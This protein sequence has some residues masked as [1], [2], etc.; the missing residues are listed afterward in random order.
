M[1]TSFFVN[2]IRSYATSPILVCG[3]TACAVLACN[4]QIDLGNTADGGA[5]SNACPPDPTPGASEAGAWD[6][7]DLG[8]VVGTWT[9]YT[10]AH[11]FPSG[12]DAIVMVFASAS[13]GSVTGTVTYGQGTPPPPPTDPNV[14]YLVGTGNPPERAPRLIEGFAYTAVQPSFDGNRLQVRTVTAEPWNP[15]CELQT[16][17]NQGF[18]CGMYGCVPNW[19]GM[20]N[21][22]TCTTTDPVSGATET[23]N[24]DKYLLCALENPCSCS[25]T[26]CAVN[27]NRPDTWL[28]MQMNGT[29]RLDGTISGD[30][31]IHFVRSSP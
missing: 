31:P 12:S 9:G 15:W 21:E 26:S 11:A 28:D 16:P 29:G 7:G 1:R 23:I 24:V 19:G 5:G 27:M 18:Q 4:P 20:C 8:S 17:T 13:D 6:S 30:I 25:A 14:G 22:T 3:A 10:E 2:G